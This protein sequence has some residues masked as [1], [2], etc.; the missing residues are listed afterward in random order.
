MTTVNIKQNDT[1]GIFTDTLTVD[2]VPVDLT[3]CTI[4][5]LLRKPGLTIAQ[6]A[7]ITAPLVG[8][9]SYQ[10]VAGDVSESGKYQQEWEVT[11]GDSR[12]LTFPNGEYNVVVIEDDLG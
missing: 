11:F 6:P 5:F 10:P 4:R 9:V 8:K 12:I 7:T 1:K 3:G 2:D